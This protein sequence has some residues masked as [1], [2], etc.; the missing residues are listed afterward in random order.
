MKRRTL[1]ASSI[2]GA[3]TLGHGSLFAQSYPTRP[4]RWVMPFPAGGPT[5][6]IAR[7]LAELASARIGQ[8]II[9]DNKTGASGSI[10]TAEVARAAPDGYTF[11][12]AIPDSLISVASLIKSVSYDARTDLTPVMKICH[13]IP[14]LVATSSLGVKD[15]PQLLAAARKSPGKIACGTWGPGTL[16]HL[17]ITSIGQAT[18]TRFMDVPYKGL[19][20]VI[21]D[22]MGGTVH[23][24]LVPPN[25]AL[26]M[27]SKSYAVPLA[28]IGGEPSPMLPG[29]PS[30]QQM[31]I[32]APILRSTLWTGLVA[33]KGLPQPLLQQWTTVLSDC[34]QDAE[35]NKFLTTAGQGPLGR[36]SADFG[37]ELA[38]EFTATN[39]LIRELG[40][41]AQ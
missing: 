35:F 34:M 5:D 12:I 29:V 6:A 33:P 28:T 20:P 3:A 23:L 11:A 30:I 25:L 27:Q 37:R 10:G 32:D 2:A 39:T 17:V 41:T 4:I 8:P 1:L 15:I 24:A 9:I 22:V 13:A 18:G 38:A 21:Q 7:K 36:T 16:P 31:G 26:Q 19:A 40:I 14:V